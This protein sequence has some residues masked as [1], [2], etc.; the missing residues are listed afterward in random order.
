MVE[1]AQ[2]VCTVVTLKPNF[3][4]DGS[5]E[6]PSLATLDRFIKSIGFGVEKNIILRIVINNRIGFQILC[7]GLLD[8]IINHNLMA[9]PLFQLF[10]LETVFEAMPII[11]IMTDL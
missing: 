1:G 2:A 8:T 3:L 11:Q 10:D 7:E 9:L 6:L 5:D 4:A